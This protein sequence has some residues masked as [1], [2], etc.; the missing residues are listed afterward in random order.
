M[1]L[2]QDHI[3]DLRMAKDPQL[4]LIIYIMSMGSSVNGS[5]CMYKWLFTL[6]FEFIADLILHKRPH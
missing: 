1:P 3:T 5:I 6:L 4:T 2:I